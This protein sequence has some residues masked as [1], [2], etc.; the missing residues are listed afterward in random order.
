M[1]SRLA[2]SQKVS[3]LVA[4]APGRP[5]FSADA[6]RRRAEGFETEHRGR[7]DAER[8]AQRRERERM[9][10]T[11]IDRHVTHELWRSLIEHAELAA[12]HGESEVL[13]LRF[14]RIVQRR[15]PHDRR[16]RTRLG[17]DAAGRGGQMFVR[18]RDELRPQG[19]RLSA[20]VVSYLDDG[21]LGDVGLFLCW[22]K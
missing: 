2:K 17:D 18:W 12:E 19:F 22:G 9:V 15:R 13:M 4:T 8:V 21:V 1:L 14:L 10:K 20:R 11:M 6:L 7:R 3:R 5:E 16:R